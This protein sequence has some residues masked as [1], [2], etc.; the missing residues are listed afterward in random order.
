[1]IYLDSWLVSWNPDNWYW[2]DYKEDS[3]ITK[4]GEIYSDQ[5]SC[6]STQ[7]KI[8]DKVYLIKLGNQPRGIIA[9]G[10]IISDYFESDH[11]NEEK[12]KKGE[13]VRRIKID[14]DRILN[15]ENDIIL[16]QQELKNKFPRQQWSPQGSGISIKDEYTDSLSKLWDSFFS[17]FKS[18]KIDKEL[19]DNISKFDPTERKKERDDLEVLRLAFI[20]DYSIDN[21][22]NMPIDDFIVGKRNKSSFC[23]R[24]ENE[25]Q[26][27]GNIHGATSA[28]FGIYYGI[29]GQDKEL[30]YRWTNRF[31]DSLDEAFKT[32]KD[33]IISLINAGANYEINKININLISPMM[34]GK[35][36]SLYYPEKYLNIFSDVHLDYFIEQL[37]LRNTKKRMSEIEK[38]RLL[39][40][41]KNSISLMNNWN[42]YE[43]FR[44]LYFTFDRPQKDMIEGFV[45]KES[46]KAQ[47]CIFPP[48]SDTK[49][50]IV[51]LEG[52]KPIEK[53]KS[54]KNGKGK[55]NFEFVNT[56]NK[57][58]GDRG[59]L[60]VIKEEEI[61]LQKIGEKHLIID[62][63]ASY[64]DFAGYDVLSYD[65][66]GNKMQI[67]VKSTRA[68]ASDATFY[69]SGNEFRKSMELDNYWIYIVYEAH[70]INPKI[71]KI[72][73]PFKQQDM[74]RM[75]PTQYRVTIS[76]RK[77]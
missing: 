30:K 24:L 66:N 54:E 57:R 28:K 65:E 56:E 64:D 31:G 21:I 60:V 39:L 17:Q 6:I 13:T 77:A 27:W 38:Q 61:K 18:N 75:E 37:S 26:L 59:E 74:V 19:I 5:W 55:I 44:Y 2:E 62:H 58:L 32:V 63:V 22:R 15:F 43:F 50:N 42:N 35:L 20:R 76:V 40:D 68:K 69:L 67:E 16:S 45:T 71:W 4:Q 41:Y 73:N 46:S 10:T 36:L 11:W 34:K 23:Y 12:R 47:T 48:L 25:L 3:E 33:E 70:T 8:G 49:S 52:Y 72:K 7:T 14:F 29:E 1:M 51:E 9:S 53:I